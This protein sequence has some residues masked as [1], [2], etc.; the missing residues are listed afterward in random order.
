MVIHRQWVVY[1]QRRHSYCY[2]QHTRLHWE[3]HQQHLVSYSIECSSQEWF[4]VINHLSFEF[5]KCSATPSSFLSAPSYDVFSPLFHH[6]SPKPAH[7]NTINTVA[8]HRQQVL[9]AQAAVTKQT[10]DPD[11]RDNYTQHHSSIS[12]P[13]TGS[14]FEQPSGSAVAAALGW[15]ARGQTDFTTLRSQGDLNSNNQLP[16]AFGI[17]PHENVS[18]SPSAAAS[19]ATKQS[20]S[21]GSSTGV[22]DTFNAH[23]PQV[24]WMHRFCFEFSKVQKFHLNRLIMFCF[25]PWIK[26]MP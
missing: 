26:Q 18:A 3:H 12:A 8:Q 22:Y 5:C 15:Q 10:A 7:F 9:A 6:A 20:A 4:S 24:Y 21:S 13:Q 25:S 1:R 11:L 14:Y 16:S 17:L 23:F 19:A 2:R